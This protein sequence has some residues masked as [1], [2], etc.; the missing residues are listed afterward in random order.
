MIISQLELGPLVGWLKIKAVDA[1]NDNLVDANSSTTFSLVSWKAVRGEP[2]I[3]SGH[4]KSSIDRTLENEGEPVLRLLKYGPK[5]EFVGE[6]FQIV[7]PGTKL[8][9]EEICWF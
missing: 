7:L 5:R 2:Q 3:Q 6:E 4:W 9:P 1:I 8:S